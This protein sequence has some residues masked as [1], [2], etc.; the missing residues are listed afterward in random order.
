KYSTVIQPRLKIHRRRFDDQG[1]REAGFFHSLKSID[2]QIIDQ[3]ER[4]LAFWSDVDV[5]SLPV[6]K[7]EPRNRFNQGVGGQASRKHLGLGGPV[8]IWCR[9]IQS[10]LDRIRIHRKY[11]LPD[12]L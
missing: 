2:F 6:L 11:L 10:D 12:G 7:L 4:V 1:G 3:R 9:L 8:S 5:A